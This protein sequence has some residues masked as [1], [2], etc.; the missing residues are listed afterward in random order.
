MQ[1]LAFA[2]D[3]D[4]T[5]SELYQ[6]AK[7]TKVVAYL[8]I[9]LGMFVFLVAFFGCCGV[10]TDSCCLLITVGSLL[11]VLVVKSGQCNKILSFLLTETS[12]GRLLQGSYLKYTVWF[13]NNLIIALA[14]NIRKFI[15]A[16]NIF[17]VCLLSIAP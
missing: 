8:C 14:F 2:F 13:K 6:N 9:G 1:A 10:V 12:I 4:V 3:A 17:K 7:I 16:G 11:K 15:P 5:G